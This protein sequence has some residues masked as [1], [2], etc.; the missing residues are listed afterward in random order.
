MEKRKII[1]E[2]ESKGLFV[3]LCTKNVF[4]KVYSSNL[5]NMN[6]WE[7]QDKADYITAM[8]QTIKSFFEGGS[9][10]E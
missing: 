7:N 6:I 8:E 10:N 5:S 2:R 1:I 3:P 9:G 4:L